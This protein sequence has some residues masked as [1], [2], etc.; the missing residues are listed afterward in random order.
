M[1]KTTLRPLKIRILP[2]EKYVK[3]QGKTVGNFLSYAHGKNCKILFHHLST[4]CPPKNV[5]KYR[6]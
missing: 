5:D 3:K 1:L 4:G 6:R 2:R